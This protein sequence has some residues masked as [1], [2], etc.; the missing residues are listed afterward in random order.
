MKAWAEKFYTGQQW[1]NTRAA[2]LQSID[3]ICERC[4]KT[5][6]IEIATVVHHKVEL[7]PDNI[8]DP[9]VSLNWDNLE[10][11]CQDCHN[12]IHHGSG[13]G[14]KRYGFDTDGNILPA[15]GIPPVPRQKSGG[16]F[17]ERAP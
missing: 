10:G 7:T 17:T 12:K 9:N 3:Y 6:G 1:K 11:V 14:V 13:S 5:K 15:G 8:G 4:I 2:Y 16:R